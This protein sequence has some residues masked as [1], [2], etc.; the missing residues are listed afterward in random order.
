MLIAVITFYCIHIDLLKI[1]S[2]MKLFP[3]MAM[4]ARQFLKYDNTIILKL[5]LNIH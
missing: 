5:H 3:V 1:S 4:S 2:S